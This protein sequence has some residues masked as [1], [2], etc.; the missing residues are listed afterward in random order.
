MNLWLELTFESGSTGFFRKR[1]CYSWYCML[2]I[3]DSVYE[4]DWKGDH[5]FILPN[6]EGRFKQPKQV[7]LTYYLMNKTSTDLSNW[8]TWKLF[9]DRDTTT[10]SDSFSYF[11]TEQP[12]LQIR[13]IVEFNTQSH[14]TAELKPDHKRHPSFRLL[15]FDKTI[16]K[17]LAHNMKSGKIAETTRQSQRRELNSHCAMLSGCGLSIVGKNPKWPKL[18]FAVYR[19]IRVPPIFMLTHYQI[20]PIISI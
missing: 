18:F 15:A 10:V 7:T 20:Q 3:S 16:F 9:I 11:Q 12:W 17:F 8:Q 4:N 6:Y 2:W 14:F 5:T 13:W 1:E 19:K